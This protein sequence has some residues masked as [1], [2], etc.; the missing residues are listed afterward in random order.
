[1]DPVNV[2]VDPVWQNILQL[3]QSGGSA[4]TIVIVYVAYKLK[5][6][7]EGYFSTVTLLLT[8]TQDTLKK[9][10]ERVELLEREVEQFTDRRRLPRP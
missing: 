8:T 4:G 9:L 2:A 5:T 1:M 7:V 10:I 6:I 3:L